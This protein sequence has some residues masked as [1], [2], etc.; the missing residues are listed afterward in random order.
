M[1]EK[2]SLPVWFWIVAVIALVWNLMGVMNFI[3][4]VTMSPEA[5]A[6]L[7]ENQQTYIQTV[8]SWAV[9][10]FAIAVFGGTLGCILLLLRKK[11][12]IILLTISLIGILVQMFHAFFIS[13]STDDFGPGGF[14][15][16][17][18]IIVIGI[19]L[20]WFSKSAKSKGW[21]S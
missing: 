13:D 12:A 4:Q 6:T 14:I 10:A 11:L 1:S 21:I 18:M 7:P 9:S 8:P 20:V 5:L 16:P 15:M 2:V 3:G 17:I 19:L